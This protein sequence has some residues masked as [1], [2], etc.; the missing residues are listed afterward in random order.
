MSSF[1]RGEWSE[2]YAILCLLICPDLAIGDSNLE[3]VSQNLYKLK[4][5]KI[6]DAETNG[7]IEYSLKNKDKVEIYYNNE[8]NNIISILELNENK[9]RIFNAIENAPIGNGAFEI[10]GLDS[11]LVKL[12]KGKTIKAKSFNKEDLTALVLD[13]RIG[14]DKSLKYSIKSSLGSPATL[15]N[16]SQH[17]N[18][19]YS[20]KGLSDSDIE[21]INFIS[22]RTK[23]VDRI[24][25]IRDKGGVISFEK[26]SDP[27]FEYNLRIIDSHM[28]HYLGNV[29]LESYSS[30]NKN[31]KELFENSNQF[32]DRVFALK[33]L[34]DF[35]EGISFGF[36]PS[37]KW[38][39]NKQVNGGLVIVK[40]NGNIIILD[41][42]YYRNEVLK[43]L[44]NETK[45][46]SPSST[47]YHMLSLYKMF[48]K[49]Y[50]T[51]NLQIR[52]KR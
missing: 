15:L 51:L 30:E 45:L 9:N 2:I 35:L 12:T 44:M 50:F 43:Y 6:D 47:R 4:K 29:L 25:M 33:K 24:K 37:I 28:P 32:E 34:G 49:T 26:V 40:E 3:V 17:T 5:I 11:L 19:L 42:I 1:N 36:F 39:G 14:K 16:S 13:K 31:L 52:Y 21:E 48:D 41:L 20:V 38:D 18:F 10:N 23:L 27:S 22:T 46:D 7:I 8:L